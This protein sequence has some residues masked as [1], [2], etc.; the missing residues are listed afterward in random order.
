MF[1]CSGNG[2]NLKFVDLLI[3]KLK[4]TNLVLSVIADRECGAAQYAQK[5]GIECEI[6]KISRNTQ[7]E[8]SNLISEKSPKIIFTT[9]EKVIS[10][11]V[12]EL[13]SDRMVNL[14]YSLLPS[15]SG[16]VGIKGI[17]LAIKN[18]DELIGVTVHHL[19]SELDS[20]EIIIQSTFQNP[21]NYQTA[22]KASFRIGCLQIWT[23]LEDLELL[24]PR[25]IVVSSDLVDN[26]VIN[27]KPN[28]CPF[29]TFINEEFWEELASL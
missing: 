11:Q 12:L 21:N 14:H 8:L 3:K 16:L 2:G 4:T 1:L 28:V 26:L 22:V 10:P 9:L 6:I 24:T 5:S 13:H 29:P 25:R 7:L 27:H 19:T 15:Y 23:L 17:E 18:Q 20:G